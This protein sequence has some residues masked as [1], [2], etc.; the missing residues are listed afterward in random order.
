MS[1]FDYLAAKSML[2]LTTCEDKSGLINS[3]I[4]QVFVLVF[5]PKTT[6]V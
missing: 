2:G 6:T 1:E 4:L 3:T 5:I